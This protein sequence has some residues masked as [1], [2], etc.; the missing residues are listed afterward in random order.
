M[1]GDVISPAHGRGLRLLRKAPR[2]WET[3]STAQSRT[4][5]VE[6]TCTYPVQQLPLEAAFIYPAQDLTYGRYL[7]LLSTT[8]VTQKVPTFTQQ[9]T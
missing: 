4:E 5:H 1:E 9:T 7:H 2:T 6:G 8:P 3:L